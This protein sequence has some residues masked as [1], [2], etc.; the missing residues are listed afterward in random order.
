MRF[1]H[2]IR[3]ALALPLILSLILT[4]F[5]MA[6]FAASHI[7]TDQLIEDSMLATERARI[8]EFMS[9]EDVRAEMTALGVD[10]DEALA[11]INSFSDSEIQL[12]AGQIHAQPAGEGAIGPIIGA[13]VGVF[14]ILLITDLLCLTTVFNF[15]KCAR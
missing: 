12:I 10:P 11:R 15:T 8:H 7:S 1:F 4:S 13:L 6:G 5:P 3:V 2:R 9:R 14:I